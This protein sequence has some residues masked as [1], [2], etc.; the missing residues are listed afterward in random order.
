ML[1]H[2]LA[3]KKKKEAQSTL[4]LV[5][6]YLTS[7]KCMVHLHVYYARELLQSQH[8]CPQVS[9]FFILL[10]HRSPDDGCIQL[11]SY[12]F[13]HFPLHIQELTVVF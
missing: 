8:H 10:P 4:H 12:S 7:P 3:G 6:R 9:N 5:N 11:I 2:P 1:K 13:M